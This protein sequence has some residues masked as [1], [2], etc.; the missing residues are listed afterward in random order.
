[1]IAAG[2][3]EKDPVLVVF[4][5]DVHESIAGLIAGRL[6]ESYGR[7]VFVL[8]KGAEGVKGSGRST[9]EYSMYE[10][11]CKCSEL[12][13]R[14][15]GHPM[16]AGLSLPEENVVTFR[17]RINELCS[18]TVEELE[19]RIHIDMQMPVGY[20]TTNL[21]SEFSTLAPFGKGNTRPLFADKNLRVRRMWIV[22]KNRT[23]LRLQMVSAYGEPVSVIYFGDIPKFQTYLIE[24]F[25]KNELEAA[26]L[27]RENGMF[28]SIVYEPKI[29]TYRDNES[30]QFEMKDYR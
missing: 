20:V 13:T 29:D 26:M 10:E 3:Y 1:M 18:Y 17:K 30:L 27:G 6:R 7:P 11:M 24:K 15:G 21:V 5:P 19:P 4:L 12:F 14:F 2:N 22:G 25:G 9:E 16:A 8:T 28:L 23:V